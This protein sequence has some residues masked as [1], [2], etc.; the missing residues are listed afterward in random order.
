MVY[1]AERAAGR[2]NNLNLIRM[3]AATAV[4]VSHAVPISQGPQ[5][6]EP[7]NALTGYTLGTLS[8]M[9]FFVISGFLITASFQRSS[10]HTSF[11]LARGLR[12]LPGLAVNLVFVALVL[13]PVVTALPVGAF[14]NSSEPYAFVLRNLALF[15]L[16]YELPGVFDDQPYPAIVGSIWTLRHE[17]MCYMGVFLAGFAGAWKSR[18]RAIWALGGYAVIWAG[19]ALTDPVLSPPARGLV[20]LSL[21][22]ATGVA[23]YVWRDRL[24]LSIFGVALTAGLA[25]AA[26]GSWIYPVA[27]VLTVGYGTFWL[28]YIPG[29]IIRAYNRLGDYSYGVYVYAFPL[30]GAAVWAFGPQSPLENILYSFPPTLMLSVLSWHLIEA[31]AM[32]AKAPLL[33]LLGKKRPVDT[34]VPR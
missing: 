20:S 18:S 4:L 30:Q 15:S 22:F 13:A 34:S 17:V 33:T 25:W 27:V 21:P 16:V 14:L 10:S 31:P 12:L 24:Q 5:A 8:V 6:V 7:L 19:I 26:A 3:L 29:G 9:V 2:D 11:L 32:R 23:F 1:L 28:A